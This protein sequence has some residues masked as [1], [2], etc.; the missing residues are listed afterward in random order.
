MS[1]EIQKQTE[2]SQ[3]TDLHELV[4]LLKTNLERS[5][6]ILK[7]SREVKVY[8]RW[9]NIWG[10]VRILVIVVPIVLGFIYLP[11]LFKDV[12]QSYRSLLQQ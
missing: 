12:F 9:Q 3:S 2:Y 8:L 6:E 4:E 11:P 10:I 5:E 1:E 7:I